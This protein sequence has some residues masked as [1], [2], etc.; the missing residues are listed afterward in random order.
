MIASL[1]LPLTLTLIR[2][3]LSPILLPIFLTLYLPANNLII[4]CMLAVFFLLFALTDLLDGLLARRFKQVTNV[5]K[6]LDPIADKFMVYSTLITLVYVQKLYFYWAIIIIGREFFVMALRE[7]AL[8]YRFTV[9]VAWL[10]KI[11]TAFQMIFITWIIINPA[12]NLGWQAPLWN[13]IELILLAFTLVF[14]IASAVWY[15]HDFIIKFKQ[16]KER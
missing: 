13:G 12:Q 1:N 15:Y 14:T 2:L 6:M 7:I 11:K 16:I 4:N 8:F 5:G 3:V 10:G 9:P